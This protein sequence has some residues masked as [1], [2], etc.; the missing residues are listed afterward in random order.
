MPKTSAVFGAQLAKDMLLKIEHCN[1]GSVEQ[2][3]EYDLAQAAKYIE[4]AFSDHRTRHGLCLV[5]AEF[6]SVAV[7]S[8]VID[9]QTWQPLAS[10]PARQAVTA[11]RI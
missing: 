2:L 5:L 8:R 11:K 3:G 7:E 6:L 10:L 9:L 1:Q 4:E